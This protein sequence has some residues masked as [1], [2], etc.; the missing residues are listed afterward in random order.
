MDFSQIIRKIKLYWLSMEKTDKVI[1]LVLVFSFLIRIAF[2]FYSPLRGWDE[3]VYLNL[4]HDLSANPLFYS[5]KNSGWNDFI[6][7]T[8]IIYGWPNVGFRAPLLPYILSVF[9]SLKLNF[10]IPI[11]IPFLGTLSVF[12]V[13]I[14]GKKLFDKKVGLYSAILFAL[15]PIHVFYSGKIWTDPLVV[16]FILLTFISFWE[17]YEK[18]NKKHKVLFGLFLALSL[19]ARYTTL[20]ITPI[21]L[22]YFLIRDKSLKFLKDKYLWY[23]IG[24]FF[25]TL[26]PWFIYGFKYYGNILG[27]FIHGFKAAGY[28]GGVQ[29]WNFFF[30]NSWQIF[31]II[32]IVSVFSL[33]FIFIK[34]EFIKREIYL[35]LIWI[36]F[37]SIMVMYMPHK[38]ER[39]IMPIIPAICIIS[40]FFISKLKKYKNIIFG[41]I[42]IVLL[43]SLWGMFKV[44]YENA[45]SGVNLCFSDGNKFLANN[46]INKSSLVITNQL[47]I[48]HY[49]TQKEVH[50]YPDLWDFDVFRNI[51]DSNYKDRKVYIFFANYDMTDKKIKNDLDNNFKKVFECSKGWGNSTIYEYK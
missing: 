20:W 25:L 18:E 14:L 37:F 41:L 33:L 27:A 1:I 22:F 8:D 45:Y 16:F 9:Y 31:S 34:K 42:C 38:E 7:S 24:I 12:L 10:L 36:I 32:G 17:G 48:V 5:L 13:Y 35:L 44:E 30:V 47:P 26:V 21:F 43:T 51:I 6:P 19:L 28:W 11:I 46:S 49:Y 15:I 23:A 40:G 29:S 2:L 4:G 3:T 50:L 39:F